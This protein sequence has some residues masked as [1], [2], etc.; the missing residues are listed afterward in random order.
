MFTA[1]K[2][3]KPSLFHSGDIIICKRLFPACGGAGLFFN[4]HFI[5]GVGLEGVGFFAF[6]WTNSYF[7]SSSSSS[8]SPGAGI[9]KEQA[10]S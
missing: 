1:L 5:S 6:S 9:R 2:K 7:K 10:R 3:K 4:L 8:N